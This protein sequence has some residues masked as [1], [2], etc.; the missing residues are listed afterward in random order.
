VSAP[1]GVAL[2]RA[3]QSG[4]LPEPGIARLLGFTFTT[5]EPG[6]VECELLTRDDMTNPMGSVH[7]GIAATLLDT[8]MGC[9]VQSVL[10]TGEALT[11]TDLQVRYVRSVEPGTRVR[12]EGTVVHR[13]RRL[14]TAEGRLVDEDGRPVAH[15]TTACMI[16]AA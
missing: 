5:I 10:G 11:T 13:G 2:L 12:A 6:R 8:V 9:A 16:F 14:A 4:E 3:I 7:G 15:A 1:A